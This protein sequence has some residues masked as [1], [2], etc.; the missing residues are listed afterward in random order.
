MPRSA[1]EPSTPSWRIILRLCLTGGVP[2]RSL[3]VALIVGAILNMINQG[4]VLISG[5]DIDLVKV[6]LTFVVPYCVATY[7][8]VSFQVASMTAETHT[9]PQT[10]GGPSDDGTE[11]TSPED[12]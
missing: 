3:L 9:P 4:D 8:A 2:R 10:A 5:A 11:V 6:I 12:R 7:G 1:P